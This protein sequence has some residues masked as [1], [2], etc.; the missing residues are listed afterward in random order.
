M[1]GCVVITGAGGLLGRAMAAAFARDGR[2]VV[3]ADIDS[4]KLADSVAAVEREGRAALAVVTDVSDASAMDSLAIAAWDRFGRIDRLCLNAGLAILK[5]FAEQTRADWDMVMGVQWGGVLNGVLSFLPRLI[6]QGGDRHI[7][8]VSSMS[9]VGRADLRQLNA[10][11]VA[12][13]FASAG[14][15]ETMAPAM[16]EHGI[17][18][19]LLCPGMTVADPAAMAGKSWPMPSATWY[20]DN[21]L[22]AAQVADE[23]MAGIAERRLYIFPHRAGRQE[24]IDRHVRLMEGFDQAER[25]SPPIAS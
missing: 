14:L 6:E 11:Y 3:L 16:E 7:L 5:P 22:N 17:G 4:S 20:Q 24:V 10:P 8:I 15:A 21:L 23:V 18:V 9:G 19:S 2:D 1:K 12:A 25:T 13:K